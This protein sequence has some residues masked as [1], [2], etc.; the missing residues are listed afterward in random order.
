MSYVLLEGTHASPASFACLRIHRTHGCLS[1]G[2]EY[3]EHT[4]ANLR[5]RIH[6]THPRCNPWLRITREHSSF[7]VSSQEKRP[8]WSSSLCGCEGKGDRKLQGVKVKCRFILNESHARYIVLRQCFRS[9]KKLCGCSTSKPDLR[10][11]R[12][13]LRSGVRS[14]VPLHLKAAS[15]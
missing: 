11:H 10:L 4:G 9:E 5:L 2:S 14:E 6:H 8:Q 7:L 3:T 15:Q 1:L 12:S 13:R